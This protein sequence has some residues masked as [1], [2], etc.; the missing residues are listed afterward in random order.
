MPISVSCPECFEEYTVKDSLA[1]TKVR[2]K[3]CQGSIKVEQ[4]SELLGKLPG[5]G[6]G[7]VRQVRFW[8]SWAPRNP[9]P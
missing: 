6:A 8:R 3:A 2:C 1:G 5:V 7:Q 9:V 4:L